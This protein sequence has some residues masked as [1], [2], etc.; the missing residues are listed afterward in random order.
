MPVAFITGVTG[1]DGSYLAEQLLE[2][3]WRV[4]GLMRP[5]STPNPW[6]IA[7]LDGLELI[8]GDLTDATRLVT[9]L[10][11]IQP[12]HVYNLA[13]QSHVAASWEQPVWTA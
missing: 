11:E 5:S 13:A 12:D 7:H 9:I 6:R 8:G 1:Q 10:R 4:V 3:G 2:Q